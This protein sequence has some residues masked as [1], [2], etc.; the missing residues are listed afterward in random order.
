MPESATNK[1]SKYDYLYLPLYSFRDKVVP[2]SSG[3]NAWNGLPKN[4][5]SQTVRPR[6]E[7]YIPIPKIVW[8]KYPRWVDPRVDMNDYQGYK[9]KT[10]KSS[11]PVALHM[12]D[13]S[14]I[15]AIITQS[16]FKSLQ[17]NP[18]SILGEWLLNVFGITNPQRES[19]DKPAKKIVTMKLL[20]QMGYDSLK[21][22][23][24]YPDKP[25]DIWVDLAEYGSFERFINDEEV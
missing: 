14:V 17:T 5:G 6:G 1:P 10:G 12:P 9:A 4:K 20:Q 21:L 16:G 2:E 7:A 15:D 3:L 22:W 11:Y 19:Y 8:K 18:Q 13:G 23:H 24:K 25:H